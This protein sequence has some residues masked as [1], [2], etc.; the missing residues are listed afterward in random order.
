M[1]ERLQVNMLRSEDALRKIEGEWEALLRVSEV[2]PF[3]SPQWLLP[4][5]RQFGSDDLRVALLRREGQVIGL[6]PLYVYA[7]PA[8][9]ERKL[10]LLGVGTSDY[11]DG[12]FAPACAVEDVAAALEHVLGEP[13]WDVLSLSQLRPES[14]LAQAVRL[15]SGEPAAKFE[16]EFCSRVPAV[17]YAELPQKIRRNAMY[18]RNRAHRAGELELVFANEANCL[19]AFEEFVRLH[20]ARWNERGESGVMADPR[21]LAWHREALPLLARAEMLRLGSLRLNGETMAMSYGLVDVAGRSARCEYVYLTAFS[22]ECAELRPGTLLLAEVMDAAAAEGVET[23]DLLRGEESYKSLWHA[24]RVA[25]MGFSLR[26]ACES[27]DER[28]AA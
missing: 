18:Y 2:T 21:V 10:M 28:V 9:G 22:M 5:W 16:T 1:R 27:A 8:N 17:R 24:E 6:L 19:E 15:V 3:Q 14:K 12:V 4:W 26:A 7:E 23:V 20:T 25:T 13:G 11:L